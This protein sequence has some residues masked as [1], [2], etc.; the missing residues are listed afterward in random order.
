MTEKVI[1]EYINITI[2]RHIMQ[3]SIY[4]IF[5]SALTFK[6]VLSL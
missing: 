2:S 6:Y 1:E 4:D 5:K 3:I